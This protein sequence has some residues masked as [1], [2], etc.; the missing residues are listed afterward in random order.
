[1]NTRNATGPKALFAGGWISAVTQ[2]VLYREI[3]ASVGGNELVL[4][5][6]LAGYLAWIALG[7]AIERHAPARIPAAGWA[8]LGA[9]MGL[10]EAGLVRMSGSLLTLMNAVGTANWQ[11]GE[12]VPLLFGVLLAFL[13]SLPSSLCF[14]VLFP[15]AVREQPDKPGTFS[16]AYA[17][18]STGYIS[19]AAAGTLL[20]IAGSGNVL[21]ASLGTAGII[22]ILKRPFLRITAAAFCILLALL[23]ESLELQT[24][25][26]GGLILEEVENVSHSYVRTTAVSGRD[27]RTLY[28]DSRPAAEWPSPS[29]E[30]HWL[31]LASGLTAELE[32]ATVAAEDPAAA[33]VLLQMETTRVSL[34]TPD[35]SGLRMLLGPDADLLKDPRVSFLPGDPVRHADALREQDFVYVSTPGPLNLKEARFHTFKFH[36]NLL[37]A[38]SDG[39]IVVMPVDIRANYPGEAGSRFLKAAWGGFK[40]VYP[41]TSAFRAG[42]TAYFLGSNR[43]I[44][45]DDLADTLLSR[46][47]VPRLMAFLAAQY[48]DSSRSNELRQSLREVPSGNGSELEVFLARLAMEEEMHHPGERPVVLRLMDLGPSL[49]AAAGLLMVLLSVAAAL[50]RGAAA[51]GLDAS[52]AGLAG[53]AAEL[54]VM[55][56]YQSA[57]G[58]IYLLGG[59]MVAGFMLGFLIGAWVVNRWDIKP[60]TGT[61]APLWGLLPALAYCAFPVHTAVAGDVLPALLLVVTGAG[62]GVNISSLPRG[63]RSSFRSHSAAAAWTDAFDHLGGAAGGLAVPLL[64]VPA[65]GITGSMAAVAALKVLSGCT[66][67][68]SGALP[69]H[70]GDTA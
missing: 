41:F 13:V 60:R 2:V 16:R 27:T 11:K 31:F 44:N 9:V 49:L 42:D 35:R 8:G 57:R 50:Q 22:P 67:L 1:M 36:Q 45:G 65:L 29:G 19:G 69:R 68:L 15:R 5:S 58:M 56:S 46:P 4:G 52:S 66:I 64:M 25:D 14:G 54:L 20:L 21:L 10:L 63:A 38:L 12:T 59:V 30:Y 48:L 61:W 24:A 37:K 34:I 47:G 23:A 70:T 62:C 33:A 32:R 40:S 7:A 53:L 51:A 28:S 3:L 43:K 18:E 26:R 17:A 6:F 39:G 55:F